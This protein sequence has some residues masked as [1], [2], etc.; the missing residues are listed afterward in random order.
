MIT[1][2]KKISKMVD[3]LVTFYLERDGKN[4]RLEIKQ[5]PEG[6]YII[7]SGQNLNISKEELDRLEHTINTQNREAELEE[8]YWTL[9]GDRHSSE[10]LSLI[11]VMVDTAGVSYDLDSDIV[12]ISLFRKE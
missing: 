8:Y 1:E 6:L 10:E 2:N 11:A 12:H 7:S 3:E 4:I 9:A 5:K